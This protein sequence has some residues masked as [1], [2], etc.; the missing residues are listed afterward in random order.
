MSDSNKR[1]TTV[2]KNNHNNHHN[3]NMAD[4]LPGKM[5][6]TDYFFM[7]LMLVSAGYHALTVYRAYQSGE[8]VLELSAKFGLFFA[9]WALRNYYIVGNKRERGQ[10]TCGAVALGYV[11]YTI[12]GG[13]SVGG[14]IGYALSTLGA[15]AVAGSYAFV[16]NLLRK[17]SHAEMA[18][19]FRKTE[20]W[21]IILRVYMLVQGLTWG[22]TLYLLSLRLM[23]IYIPILPDVL[24]L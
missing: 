13:Y 20:T 22:V 14:V 10:F 7:L 19:K 11:I 6:A 18:L 15:F 12:A 23:Y 17:M 5:S 24:G 21:A 9:V 8:D 4:K 2:N 16:T 3:R 1:S